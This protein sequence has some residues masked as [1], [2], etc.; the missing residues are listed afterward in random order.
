MDDQTTGF[1]GRHPSKLRITYKK[2][3]DGFQ[4]DALYD[5]SYT[6][7][8][9]FRHEPPPVEYTSAGLSPLHA[10]VMA[11]F[12]DVTDEY[13]KCGV[14]NLYMSNTFCRYAYNNTKQKLHGVTRK[15]GR[16]LTTSIMQ[17]KLHNRKDQEK[18]RGTV[19]TAEIFS[20]SKCSSLI[21]VSVYDTKPVHL[22]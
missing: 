22:L 9:Y 13:H 14:E 11:L 16:G 6:F 7:T 1:Q 17:E 4:C 20:N 21:A 2:E 15:S 3:D 8:F 19:I 5:D 18:V 10:R 12:D